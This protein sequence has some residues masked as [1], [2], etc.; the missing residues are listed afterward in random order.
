MGYG[1]Y[2]HEAH[3]ALTS[4]RRQQRA[5]T[6]FRGNAL[7][8]LLDPRASQRECRDSDEHPDAL[9]IVFAF[10]VSG[11]M[12][13]IPHTLAT[14]TLP[15]FMASLEAARITDPQ[16]C[17]MAVGH[18][19]DR[20]PLQVGQFESTAALIDSW[21][22]RLW[23][24]G[25]GVGQHE[26]YE[27]AMWFAAERMQL[28]CV[29]HRGRRGFLFLTVDTLP[30]PALSVVQARR[31]LGVELERDVPIRTVVEHL[32]RAFEPFVLLAPGTPSGVEEA[33]RELLG[34]R[35]LQLAHV[36][37][38]AAICSGLIALL[39]GA[40]PSLPVFVDRL[41]GSRRDKARIARTLVGFAASIHRDGAPTT[42]SARPRLPRSR[43]SGIDRS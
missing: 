24:E 43:P 34:D 40:A 31:I 42:G 22:T 27:L 26:G 20:A 18:A 5:R 4:G 2:S 32:Q 19:S 33:W 23:L 6:V 41:A 29:E 1:S 7:D 28:D 11:S 15:T 37:D 39:E 13:S 35:V 9:G 3:V 25:G 14:A 36:D 16:L 10:D 21:L 30:N 17:F 12:G 38:T 8:P